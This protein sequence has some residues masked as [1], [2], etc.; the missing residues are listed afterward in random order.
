MPRNPIWR[1]DHEEGSHAR[2]A[3]ATDFSKKLRQKMAEADMSQS[4]LARELW[5][6]TETP[7]G[8]PAASHRY[9]ISKYCAGRI[10][11]DAHTLE[12]LAIALKCD[13][14]DLAPSV[15]IAEH[16]HDHPEMRV[17]MI[18]GRRDQV[19]LT[20]NSVMPLATFLQIMALIEA[21]PTR[22][23]TQTELQTRDNPPLNREQQRAEILSFASKGREAATKLN[24]KKAQG[25]KKILSGA[26]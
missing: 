14:S 1:S 26:S 20:L 12:R 10:V 4:D 19:H 24:A 13:P 7:R 9:R 22:A 8:T 11:P 18:A 16:E 6:E 23:P 5:G 15:V 3:A 25:S 21:V 2:F 17:T